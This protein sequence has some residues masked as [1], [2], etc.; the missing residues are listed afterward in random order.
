MNDPSTS[1]ASFASVEAIFT[2]NAENVWT[3]CSKRHNEWSHLGSLQSKCACVPSSTFSARPR[4]I[5]QVVH[6]IV[7][8]FLSASPPR[9]KYACIHGLTPNFY[10]STR[11]ISCETDAVKSEG[12][13]WHRTPGEGGAAHSWISVYDPSTSTINERSP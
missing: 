7:I 2:E 13:E 10:T 6:V 5:T 9:R 12:I 3:T 4:L 1:P 8:C 11:T